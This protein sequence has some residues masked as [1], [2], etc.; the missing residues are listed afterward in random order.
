MLGTI[1]I[2]YG[3]Y[4][5]LA[6]Q[7]LKKLIAYSSVGHMGFVLLGLASATVEGVNGAVYQMFAHGLIASMLFLL[8]G[9]LYDRTHNL[10]IDNYKGIASRMPHYTAFVTIAFFASLGLPGFAGFI[11]EIM[12][13]VGAFM[14]ETVNGL[15]PR[16]MVAVSLLGLVLGAA[17]YLWTLQR[18][19]FGEFWVKTKVIDEEKLTDLTLREYLVLLPLTLLIIAFGVFPSL[20]LD[21]ITPAVSGLVDLL[22]N[23]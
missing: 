2:I 23:K 10:E 7:N 12:V 19:F 4:N 3:G 16:W 11:A 15:V 20:L 17:Y 22:M 13:F 21:Y 18:I 8:A 14:S 5:A 1:S 9:V 6:Q